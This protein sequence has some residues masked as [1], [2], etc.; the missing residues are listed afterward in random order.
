MKWLRRGVAGACLPPLCS[1]SFVLLSFACCMLSFICSLLSA[2]GPIWGRD[3]RRGAHHTR[4]LSPGGGRV[5]MCRAPKSGG[6]FLPLVTQGSGACLAS[7]LVGWVSAGTS[8]WR[9]V[10]GLFG[11]WRAILLGSTWVRCRPSD[12]LGL[13]FATNP[14]PLGAVV[15]RHQSHAGG[16]NPRDW[17]ETQPSGVSDGHAGGGHWPGIAGLAAC[18][19]RRWRPTWG[20][21]AAAWRLRRFR[22]ST[23]VR[24]GD[25]SVLSLRKIESPPTLRVASHQPEAAGVCRHAPRTCS[26]RGV[27]G[28][29]R[30]LFG[31]TGWALGGL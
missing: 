28:S 3:R 20:T 21:A 12:G 9:G 2:H 16:N 18:P 14:F 17:G 31:P 26:V 1:R 8:W 29:R 5:W 6:L 23:W 7:S 24:G 11:G 30:A 22:D 10:A 27:W 19:V 4:G 15:F 25:A 13:Q